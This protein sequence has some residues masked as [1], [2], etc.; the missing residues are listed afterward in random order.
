[1]QHIQEAIQ[2]FIQ[3]PIVMPV[4]EVFMTGFVGCLAANI[5]S[6]L[7]KKIFNNKDE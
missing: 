4:W 3:Q 2:N 7:Y 1:M 6:Y 5:I